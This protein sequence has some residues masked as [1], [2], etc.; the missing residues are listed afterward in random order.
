[1]TAQGL[2]PGTDNTTTWTDRTVQETFALSCVLLKL[3]FPVL[4]Q[5]W[6]LS[7]SEEARPQDPLQQS[8]GNAAAS[9]HS[10]DVSQLHWRQ[11][12]TSSVFFLPSLLQPVLQTRMLGCNNSSRHK[13]SLMPPK[14]PEPKG[15]SELEQTLS[16][17]SITF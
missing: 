9:W 3:S 17:W 8:S 1:M 7:T 4:L 6:K 16:C 15:L 13:V 12:Q 10:L 5:H 11:E 14:V 2:A